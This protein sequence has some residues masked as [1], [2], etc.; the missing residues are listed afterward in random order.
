MHAYEMNGG[1]EI[2]ELTFIIRSFVDEDL[3]KYE[4][5]LESLLKSAMDG[6]PNSR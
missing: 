5:K 4:V 2:M 3:E 1:V 6:Y